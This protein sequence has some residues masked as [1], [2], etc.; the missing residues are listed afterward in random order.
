MI[1]K[2]RTTQARRRR[3]VAEIARLT[4][5]IALGLAFVPQGL[6][7]QAHTVSG[8]VTSSATLSPLIGVNV[9]VEGTNVSTVTNAT[10]GFTINAPSSTSSLSFSVLGYQTQTV[11]IGGRTTI[12]VAMQEAAVALEGIVVVGYGAQTRATVS[13]SVSSVNASDLERTSAVTT[14]SALVGRMQGINTRMTTAGNGR[15]AATGDVLDGRPGAATVI[16]IRNMGDPLFVIDGIPTDDPR[17]FNQL[18]AADIEN[19]SVL[20]D[21]AAAVYGF[22]AANGVIL[23]TTKKGDRTRPPQVRFDG[24]YGFQNFS[25]YHYDSTMTNAY[26]YLWSRVDSDQNRGIES[27]ISQE[28]INNWRQGGPGYES[29][30]HYPLVI[31]N[32]NAPQYNLNAN[33]SGG[34]SNAQY[35][36]SVGHVKSEY[37]MRDNAFSRTNVQANLSSDLTDRFR[38]GTEISARQELQDNIAVQG[39]QDIVRSLLLGIHSS[40]PFQNPWL[41]DDRTMIANG[42]SHVRRIDRTVAMY[43]QDIAGWQHDFRRNLRGN[44]WAQYELPFGPI[45]RAT[46]SHQYG[47]RSFDKQQYDFTAWECTNTQ[48][49]STCRE[50]LTPAPRVRNQ[51]KREEVEQFGSIDARYN[52]NFGAHS[53]D[54]TIAFELNGTEDWQTGIEATPPNNLSHLIRVTDIND[55]TNDWGITRRASIAG[56]IGYD[57]EQ[58]YLMTLLGR[59]DGSYLYNPDKRWGFFPGITL[60]W[61]I[62]EEPFMRDRFGFLEELKLR[63]SW[64]QTGREQGVNA[65]GYLAGATYGQGGAVFGDQLFQGAAPRGLPVRNLSW[66]KSTAKNIGFDAILF[67]NK[68]SAEFD[69]F[70]RLLTGLPAA[71]SDVLLP[72]EVGY[73]LPNE[74]LESSS[75]RGFEF[76]IRYTDELGPFNISVSPNFTIARNMMLE[77]YRPRFGNSWERFRN[78]TEERWMGTAFGYNMIGQFQNVEEIE[79]HQI[80]QDGQGNRTMLPGDFIYEDVNN[81]GIINAMDQR[82]IGYG[83]NETPI[84]SFGMQNDIT[85]GNVS[86]N[87]NWSG[88][89]GYSHSR[90]AETKNMFQGDHNGQRWT[91]DRWRRE[92]PYNPQSAWIP[93]RY[94]PYRQGNNTNSWTRGQ[95]TF[96]RTNVRY[97]RLRS[98]ELGYTIPDAFTRNVGLNGVRVFA[99]ATNPWTVDNVSH[100]RIDPEVV[101]GTAL[102][103]PTTQVITLG[104]S[105]TLGGMDDP[106]PVVPL[107]SDD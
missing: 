25:R 56:R 102:V 88:G 93:G 18:N 31:N 64:G 45:I 53:L 22:R 85:W 48:D 49:L 103:Y 67:N 29:T 9:M 79:R 99:S 41:D 14:S 106:A 33:V 42:P 60:G 38:I 72:L 1:G 83:T 11:A 40:W 36:L 7:A 80:N 90:G 23:V 55:V 84:I 13:G 86:L 96:W 2:Q 100:Y 15:N 63:A 24:N 94:P 77:P 87:I 10:G 47:T 58:K 98:V 97:I 50:V 71:R 6:A 43:D 61:R 57:Y 21:A 70:E 17:E 51:I 28:E 4:G 69:I 107:P 73:L 27:S 54:G 65:W 34:S 75:T 78:G 91:M 76:Q 95:D 37:L 20:K 62:T 16:Q 104:F 39:D 30:D 105:A 66:V 8:R 19:I 12:N 92:D 101:Q 89:T 5:L 35:Y 32:R 52:T 3:S 26:E 81:D 44:F 59:Y 68:L 82:V 46:Y 74:N